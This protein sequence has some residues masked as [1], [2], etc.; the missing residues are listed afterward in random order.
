[1][2]I[3]NF[4]DHSFSP[5]GK[6]AQDEKS[7]EKARLEKPL[8]PAQVMEMA[9]R[10]NMPLSLAAELADVPNLTSQIDE[11]HALAE[12]GDEEARIVFTRLIIEMRRRA[13]S[14]ASY[15]QTPQG[16]LFLKA[17]QSETFENNC[18]QP[19]R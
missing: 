7:I 12:R 1:M 6:N 17:R 18:D 11:A 16:E 5:D 2:S 13:H 8:H 10:W 19:T 14:Y 15:L 9:K 4:D 3:N